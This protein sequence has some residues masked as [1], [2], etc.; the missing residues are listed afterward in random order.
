[1]RFK[2]W[3]RLRQEVKDLQE[4]LE[5]RDLVER[6][7][8]ALME[9]EHLTERQAYLRLQ[10]RSRTRRVPMRQVAEQILRKM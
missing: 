2:E 10:R 4:S 1:M 6:A 3:E 5:A 8:R 7:K 9:Q